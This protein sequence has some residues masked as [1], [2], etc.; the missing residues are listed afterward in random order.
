MPSSNAPAQPL[1]GEPGEN[2][3]GTV[4]GI[5][6]RV[7]TMWDEAHQNLIHVGEQNPTRAR[8]LRDMSGHMLAT[9]LWLAPLRTAIHCGCAA[10]M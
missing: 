9:L 8:L 5:T 4:D 1:G 2:T 3:E 10:L 6:W 7:F